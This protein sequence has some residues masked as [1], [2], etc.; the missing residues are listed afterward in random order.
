MVNNNTRGYNLT[1]KCLSHEN[2]A[3]LALILTD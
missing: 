2:D 3:K 1:R